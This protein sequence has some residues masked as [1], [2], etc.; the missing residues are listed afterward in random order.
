M[1][2]PM[3]TEAVWQTFKDRLRG[4][5]ARQVQR[6]E[7]VEDVL[8]DVFLRIH[9]HLGA[10]QQRE[11]LTSWIFQI[12]RNSIM[13]LHRSRRRLED[14]LDEGTLPSPEPPGEEDAPEAQRSLAACLRPLMDALE[15][16]YREALE[17]VEL[18]GKTHAEAAQAMGI[19]L[20]G[21]KS[22][23]QRARRQLRVQLEACC[24]VEQSHLGEILDYAPQPGHPSPCKGC[25]GDA[26]PIFPPGPRR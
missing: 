2:E 20:S 17:Q 18:E 25:G 8:Q 11:R 13:D 24:R 3:H 19:S 6:P 7:D 5:V 16:P 4:F 26:K 21:M 10:L 15:A 22:R 23:V 9:R 1:T 14:P 12:T